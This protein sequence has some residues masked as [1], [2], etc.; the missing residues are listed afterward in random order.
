[1]CWAACCATIW[2][3]GASA[4]RRSWWRRCR[5]TGVDRGFNQARLLA[6]EIGARFHLP[7]ASGLLRRTRATTSQTAFSRLWREANV[8]GAFAVRAAAEGARRVARLLDRLRGRVAVRGRSV[9]LVDDVMTTGSTVNEC[10]RALRK[11]G[12][13]RVVVATVAKTAR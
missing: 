12:A 8:R 7:V 2:P 11:A 10:A 3:G 5:C 9:L 4:G 1:M 13:R 6:L